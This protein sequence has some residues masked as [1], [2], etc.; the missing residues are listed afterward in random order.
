MQICTSAKF[1]IRFAAKLYNLL[2][3]RSSAICSGPYA[4]R[5]TTIEILDSFR[6]P[7]LETPPENLFILHCT[8]SP[9]GR[10][11][12]LQSSSLSRGWENFREMIR[13]ANTAVRTAQSS[14]LSRHSWPA[15]TDDIAR[16]GARS[17]V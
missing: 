1:N 15:Q 13:K 9:V 10:W 4:E 11:K 5:C 3:I 7:N 17:A 14:R 12:Y 2:P 6:P 8:V 16:P